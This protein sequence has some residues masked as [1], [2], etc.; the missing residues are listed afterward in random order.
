MTTYR[1]YTES[2][3]VVEVTGQFQDFKDYTF[4]FDLKELTM[5]ELAQMPESLAMHLIAVYRE[6]RK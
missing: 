4:A 3:V 2:Q 5:S 6:S 1:V